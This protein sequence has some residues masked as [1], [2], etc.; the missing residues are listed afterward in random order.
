MTIHAGEFSE[1]LSSFLSTMEGTSSGDVPCGEC[2]GCCTSSKFIL[3]R[4]T[5][6]E[7]KSVI[8]NELL[9]PVPG[10]PEGFLLMGYDENG[11]CPM[12]KDGKCS[13]YSARPETCRQ[14]DCR[15]LA[16]T[17]ASPE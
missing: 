13:I 8:P 17:G 4:P 11:H 3:V 5:D 15:V 7:A 2:V 1:W 9:F 10:L 16:A 12:F 14:Y 6:A